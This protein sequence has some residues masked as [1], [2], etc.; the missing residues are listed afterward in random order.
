MNLLKELSVRTGLNVEKV[1][2]RKIDINKG[3]AELEAYFR[4]KHVS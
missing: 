3:I 2:I 4:D 1:R